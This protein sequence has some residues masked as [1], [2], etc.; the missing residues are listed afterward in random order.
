MIVAFT[1][2]G[3]NQPL[4]IAPASIDAW[5]RNAGLA[6]DSHVE[7]PGQSADITLIVARA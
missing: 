6:P 4:G 7:L 1:G 2:D 3:A 5:C